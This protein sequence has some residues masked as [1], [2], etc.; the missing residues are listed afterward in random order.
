[1]FKASLPTGLFPT[2][3]SRDL[4]RFRL[5]D[6]DPLQGFFVFCRPRRNLRPDGTGLVTVPQDVPGYAILRRERIQKTH[7]TVVMHLF[8]GCFQSTVGWRNMKWTPNWPV[9]GS[10]AYNCL[11]HLTALRAAHGIFRNDVLI[12][13]RGDGWQWHA[14]LTSAKAT[15]R[16]EN[17]MYVYVDV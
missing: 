3:H 7:A 5:L 9:S 4:P 13:T 8:C 14:F 17:Y 10:Y 12:T 2:C 1:M 6:D 15:L 11:V 16:S